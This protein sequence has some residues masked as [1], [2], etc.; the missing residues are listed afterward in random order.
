MDSHRLALLVA[1]VAASGSCSQ[2]AAQVVGSTDA[3]LSSDARSPLLLD[4]SPIININLDSRSVTADG[5]AAAEAVICSI[6][7]LAPQTIYPEVMI[8]QDISGSMAGDRWQNTKAALVDVANTLDNRFRLG[9]YFFP[10]L[11]ASASNSCE[12]EKL[13]AGQY[14]NVA[15]ALGNGTK[16]KTALDQLDGSPPYG[17]TPTAEALPIVRDYLK[18]HST[19]PAGTPK[20]VILSTDGSPNCTPPTGDG[21]STNDPVSQAATSTA[22][23]GL[24]DDGVISYVIGY[25]IDSNLQSVMNGWA[26]T[27]GGSAKYINV[28]NQQSLSAALVS[29]ANAI[30]SC[31]YQ[32]DT[33]P[34][35]PSYVR[36][37]IDGQAVKFG[38]QN[39]WT[40][41]GDRLILQG[42]ACSLLR[43]GQQHDLNVQVECEPV[44]IW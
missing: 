39:G 32:L 19:S 29:I 12:L 15:P 28:T 14:V 7:R 41:T 11:K 8:A 20:Y 25:A 30:V 34:S 43:D 21:D 2:Q 16:I 13:P 27:G 3:A 36:V 31:E 40:M 33:T 44:I 6:I 4:A 1:V 22:I 10:K 23:K 35:N 17:G 38:D 37:Q 5:V 26:A 9:L 18:S 42:T 24:R